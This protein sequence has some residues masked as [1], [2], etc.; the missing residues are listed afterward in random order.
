MSSAVMTMAKQ[1][2]PWGIAGALLLPL[3][4]VALLSLFVDDKSKDTALA[5][6]ISIEA[7]YV[8][9]PPNGLWKTLIAMSH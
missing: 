2:A 7:Y 3:V 4:V 8:E 1:H 5:A 6:A 9:N